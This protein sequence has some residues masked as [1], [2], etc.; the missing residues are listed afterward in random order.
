MEEIFKYAEKGCR[1]K[2]ILDLLKSLLRELG[3]P[4]VWT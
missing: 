4:E 2:E 3:K 1:G